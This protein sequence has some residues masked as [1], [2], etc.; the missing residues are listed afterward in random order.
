MT[1]TRDDD[2][3]CRVGVYCCGNCLIPQ[4]SL[5]HNSHL[6]HR[7]ENVLCWWSTLFSNCWR[8]ETWRYELSVLHR[9]WSIRTTCIR[10]HFCLLYDTIMIR[11]VSLNLNQ[12]VHSMKLIPVQ[13]S[14]PHWPSVSREQICLWLTHITTRFHAN[15]QL[16]EQW[17]TLY[18]LVRY[19]DA[20]EYFNRDI[21]K[22]RKHVP[23]E[24][25]WDLRRWW[26]DCGSCYESVFRARKRLGLDVAAALQYC[27]DINLF[28]FTRLELSRGAN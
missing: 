18:C 22:R 16:V 14:L 4:L 28:V 25:Y 2:N 15:K 9:L 27:S 8:W 5:G 20:R 17:K 1:M 13:I 19:L 11:K 12:Q 21:V 7:F 3:V 23:R 24:R 10:C 26:C 6:D